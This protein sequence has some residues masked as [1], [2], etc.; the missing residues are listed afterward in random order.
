MVNRK[1]TPTA[2]WRRDPFPNGRVRPWAT[3]PRDMMRPTGQFVS[4]R[5]VMSGGG[6]ALSASLLPLPLV[7]QTAG[8]RVVT[9]RIGTANLRGGGAG[10]PSIRGFEGSVRVTL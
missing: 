6:A 2:T 5:S 8:F 9:A 7:G 10:P 4:R 1:V 3:I